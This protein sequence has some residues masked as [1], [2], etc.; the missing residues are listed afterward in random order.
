M[1][2]EPLTNDEADEISDDDPGGAGVSADDI[3]QDAIGATWGAQ[4]ADRAL[5]GLGVFLVLVVLFIWAY[6]REWKM[7]VGAIVALAHDLVITV[8]VYALSGFEVTPATVT[9]VLTILGFSLYDTVVVFDKVR[10]NTKNLARTRQDLRARPPTWRSTRPWCARSTPRSWRC[11]RSVPCSTSASSRSARARSRTSRSRCSSAWRPV[12]YSSIFIATPLVVQLKEL[13]P[14]VKAGDARAL[15]HRNRK[16]GRPLRQRAGVRRG[17]ADLRRAGRRRRPARGPPT[18]VE[19]RGEPVPAAAPLAAGRATPRASGP[20]PGRSRPSASAKRAQ[21]E[22][23]APLAA[24]QEVTE[25]SGPSRTS[26]AA[27]RLIRDVPDFPEPGVVFKDI[28]PLL[29]DHDGFPP[30]WPRWPTAGRDADGAVVVDKVVGMEARGFILA[31]P[32]A[33]ALGAGFVPVRK[34]GKLPGADPRRLLRPG[35]RRG[36]PRGAPG[37]ASRQ[38]ERVLLV[39]DVLATGGTAAATRELV[40]RCGGA[41]ARASRCSWSCRSSHGRAAIGGPARCTPCTTV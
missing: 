15:Q 30:S 20:P 38:G 32:V 18:P 41:R 6:F 35:V 21:P 31:A 37:R 7:S 3:S 23:Q 2:T 36:H 28:T 5:L 8:G 40:E 22:P 4:V 17:H 27:G 13:E 10:E 12:L 9:G 11:C 25:A 33:L 34:A 16:R 1:Q 26:T 19:R 29:A 39:D 14:G 24:R